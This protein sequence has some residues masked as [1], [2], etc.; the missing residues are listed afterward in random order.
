MLAALPVSPSAVRVPDYAAAIDY[1]LARL[2]TELPTHLSYHGLAHT[3]FDVIPAA[4]RL[5]RLAQLPVEDARLL[6]VA[7]AFHDLGH[8]EVSLG[9]EEV[10]AAILAGVLPGL[11]FSADA[12]AQLTALVRSTRMPQTPANTLECLLADADLDSLGRGDFLATSIAL[13]HERTACGI[14]IA[15]PDWLVNQRN[16]LATHR[17]FSACARVLRDAGKQQNIALLDRLIA[18]GGGTSPSELLP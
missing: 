5:A 2:A 4:R 16:F 9:H 1:A 14:V 17:Y 10:G 18:V 15:W 8:I 13:W 3:R 12:I 7:A 6:E 11:G